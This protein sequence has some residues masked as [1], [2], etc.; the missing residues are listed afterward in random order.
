MN[1]RRNNFPLAQLKT[2]ALLIVFVNEYEF[3]H[4]TRWHLHLPGLQ[5]PMAEEKGSQSTLSC[6]A[7]PF[8]LDPL[9]GCVLCV[10]VRSPLWSF[11]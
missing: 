8:H 11:Y 3:H 5:Q 7:A 9:Q 1:C 10:Y 6:P 2:R 4:R